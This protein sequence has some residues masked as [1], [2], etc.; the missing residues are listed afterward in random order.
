MVEKHIPL[1]LEEVTDPVELEKAQAQEARFRRN[2]AWFES[3]A[4]EI[5]VTHRGKCIGVAG[6]ELFVAATPAEVLALVRAAHP[7]DDGRF[8]RIIPRRRLARI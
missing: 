7:D 3:H 1:I 6:E 8:T 5:Y 2:L 4:A